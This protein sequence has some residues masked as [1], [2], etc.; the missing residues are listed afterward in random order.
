MSKECDELLRR[1]ALTYGV[2]MT[3]VMEMAVREFAH[4][5][6]PQARTGIMR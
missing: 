2:S 5:H 4:N 1:L 6:L 3:S